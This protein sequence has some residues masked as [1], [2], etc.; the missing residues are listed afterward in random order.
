MRVT[1][2]IESYDFNGM[3]IPDEVLCEEKQLTIL[4]EHEQLKIEI[5]ALQDHSY[6]VVV[7]PEEMDGYR[8]TFI[9]PNTIHSF[10]IHQSMVK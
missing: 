3:K 7:T 1:K 5:R 4:I 8:H 9:Q 10:L 6:I 2:K